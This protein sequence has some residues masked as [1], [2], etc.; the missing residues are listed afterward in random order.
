MPVTRLP[1]RWLNSL[2]KWAA[3]SGRSSRLPPLRERREDLPLLTAHFIKEFDQQ[4]GKR[5]QGISEPLRRAMSAYNWPG[6]VRELRNLIESMV[7]QDHDG[8]LDLNDIQEGDS[9]RSTLSSDNHAATPSGLIGR[10]LDEVERY[11][12]E[13]TLDLTGGNR[14]EAARMLGIGARTLYRKIKKWDLEADADA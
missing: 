1:C 4:H 7:V 5:V 10:P 8:T 11:Y 3:K 6:N 2:M 9:L 12:I 14:E 13:Q